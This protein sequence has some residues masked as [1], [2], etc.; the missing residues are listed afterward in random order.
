M[1]ITI[2]S[3]HEYI[4]GS[5]L[6]LYDLKQY[7]QDNNV[8][9]ESTFVYTE[10]KLPYWQFMKDN[11]RGLYTL[12][13]MRNIQECF[14]IEDEVIIIDVRGLIELFHN[15]IPIVC[16]KLIVIDSVELTYNLNEMYHAGQWFGFRADY[17]IPLTHYFANMRF[18]ECVFLMPP[19]NIDKFK[20]K[21]NIPA[22]QFF[23]RIDPNVLLTQK[24]NNNG[25]LFVRRDTPGGEFD[26]LKKRFEVIT[27]KNEMDMFKYRGMVYH[28]RN[29]IGKY[30]QFGRVVFELIMLGKQVYFL[31]NP[32]DVCDGLSDYL[33]YYN[34]KFKGK[35]IVT[36]PEELI[37][38]MKMKYEEEPWIQK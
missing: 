23:K 11:I 29:R 33:K 28:R 27:Y 19:S 6:N 32:F 26:F 30:E 1:G 18:D 8:E 2:V 10:G 22:L 38:R 25:K 7:I 35:K 20:E 3:T 31:R 9:V 34:I 16:R 4:S 37:V 36:K 24:T 14:V 15:L 13:N 5:L 21:Y 17:S 12:N